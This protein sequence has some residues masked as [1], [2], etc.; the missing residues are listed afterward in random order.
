[1]PTAIH[2]RIQLANESKD[3]SAIIQLKSGWVVVHEDQPVNGY[4]LLLSEPVVFS[5][6]DLSEI[7]RTQYLLDMVRVGDA[8]LKVTGAYRINYETWCNLTPALHTHIVPRFKNEPEEKRILPVCKAYEA[9]T[10]RKF[11]IETD[12]K[13]IEEMRNALLPFARKS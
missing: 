12:A 8:L 5:L 1:M 7:E 4:C 2:H 11:N 10:F 6:N 3:P 9:G 13:F